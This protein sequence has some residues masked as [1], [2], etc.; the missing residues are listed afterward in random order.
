MK[1]LLA[2]YQHSKL[3]Y[4][5]KLHPQGLLTGLQ[6]RQQYPAPLMMPL[7]L[8]LLPVVKSCLPSLEEVDKSQE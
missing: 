8:S 1:T 3:A 6:V 5:L 4:H 2:A 7:A